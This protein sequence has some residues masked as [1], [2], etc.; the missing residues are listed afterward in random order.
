MKQ[1]LRPALINQFI[2]YFQPELAPIW[3]EVYLPDFFEVEV[4]RTQGLND[5]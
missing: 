3:S 1:C 2:E 5:P 4:S